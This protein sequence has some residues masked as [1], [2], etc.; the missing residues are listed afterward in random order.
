MKKLSLFTW[1]SVL[2]MGLFLMNCTKDLPINEDANFEQGPI[3]NRLKGSLKAGKKLPNPY[4]I[5]RMEAALQS[6][7]SEGLIDRQLLDEIK[8]QPTDLYVKFK[9]KSADEYDVLSTEGH[10]LFPYPLDYDY[11][12]SEGVIVDPEYGDKPEWLY[13][14]VDKE[15]QFQETHYKIIE[16][17]FLNEGYLKQNPTKKRLSDVLDILEKRSFELTGY[18]SEIK[19]KA[20]PVYPTGTILIWNTVIQ[21]REPV[22]GVKVRGRKWFSFGYGFTDTDGVYTLDEDFTGDVNYSLVMEN[23]EG[24]KIW[25]GEIFV[26]TAVYEFGKHPAAGEDLDCWLGTQKWRWTAINNAIYD[27]LQFCDDEGITRPPSDL[28][29][30]SFQGTNRGSAPMLQRIFG[31]TGFTSQQQV[32]DFLD[33]FGLPTTGIL[34]YLMQYVAP[35]ITISI[36]EDATNSQLVYGLVTH[37]CAHASHY[38]NAGTSFWVDYVNYII[39]NGAYGTGLQTD[40]GICI[41]GESWANHIGYKMAIEKYGVANGLSNSSAFESFTPLQRGS[42]SD[43]MSLNGSDWEGWIIA[44]IINDLSDNNVNNIRGTYYDNVSGYTLEM[45]YDAL[46]DDVEDMQDFKARL[47]SENSWLDYTDL[48]NL[49]QAY[50][51]Y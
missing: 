18:E 29:V 51:Y 48:L 1:V 9:I 38:M 50:Y 40:N 35:D 5:P 31:E 16:K 14:V 2:L 17:L 41:L 43:Y 26:S 3:E 28:R 15:Y 45:I 39:N 7:I 20:T 21:S 34:E 13:T 22:V 33:E 23:V 49:F 6:L 10:E 27:Y 19:L 12:D 44:G 4:T 11:G 36:D 42:S 47:L 30:S 46:D 32:E 25:G 37:E 24:F 8:I